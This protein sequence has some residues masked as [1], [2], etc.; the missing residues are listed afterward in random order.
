M[1]RFRIAIGLDMEL[2]N[3]EAEQRFLGGVLTELEAASWSRVRATAVFYSD[4]PSAFF[5]T[6]LQDG[7]EI[8]DFKWINC[9]KE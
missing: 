8:D 4:S 2:W 3:K 7:W 9:S 5:D 6:L 1:S